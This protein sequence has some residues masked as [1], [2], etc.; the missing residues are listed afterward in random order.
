MFG[1]WMWTSATITLTDPSSWLWAGAGVQA[2]SIIAGVYGDETDRRYSNGFTPAG[3][4]VV[5]NCLV[6]NHDGVFAYGES[7]LYPT[8]AGG[9]VFDAGSITFPRR[10]FR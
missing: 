5:A 6:E 2:G 7:T 1:S 9:L 10:W 3:T 8:P 4:Q